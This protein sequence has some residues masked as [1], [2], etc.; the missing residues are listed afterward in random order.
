MGKSL[1]NGANYYCYLLL[2]YFC[3]RSNKDSYREDFKVTVEPL[4]N[5]KISLQEYSDTKSAPQNLLI[6]SSCCLLP[7]AY[8]LLPIL[9]SSLW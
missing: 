6:N 7:I 4:E 2:F 1:K 8:C 3:K 5:P 9:I